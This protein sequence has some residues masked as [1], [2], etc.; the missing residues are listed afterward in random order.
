MDTELLFHSL[1]IRHFLGQEAPSNNGVFML[2]D[3]LDQ[4]RQHYKD[5]GV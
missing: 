3:C 1:Q 2:E 4:E 5:V